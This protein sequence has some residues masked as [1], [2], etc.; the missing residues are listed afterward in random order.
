MLAVPDSRIK[1]ILI[2]NSLAKE[3]DLEDLA[4]MAKS[5]NISFYDAVLDKNI[6]SDEI[7]G[8]MIAQSLGFPF[9]IL[10]RT[11]IPE[12]LFLVT[13]EKVARKLKSIAFGKD[14]NGLK[15]AMND[16]TDK[17][18]IEM[19]SKKTGLNIIP[20]F[21]TEKDILNALRLL[22]KDLQTACENLINEEIDINNTAILDEAPVSKIVDLIV[23]YAYQDKASDIHIEPEEKNLLIRFRID[24]LLHDALR[25]PKNLHVRIVSRI[26]VLSKLRTDEHLSAQDGKMRLTTPYEVLDIRV[27]IIPVA[28]GEKVVLRL[29]SSKKKQFSL[30]NLGVDD[31][32]LKKI[33]KAL[34]KSYG[35]ILSTGPTGSGKTTIIYTLLKQIN[36]RE[37]NITTI[38]DPVEY[39]IA[40]ANQIQVNIKTN[41]TFANG[42]R[43]ILRQDPNVIF[44]GEIRDNETA[45]IAVN[46]ALTGHL[47]FSTLHT[48]D[49]SASIPRLIDMKVE[50]FLVASTVNLIIA[51]RL[52]RKICDMCRMPVTLTMNDLAQ[53]IPVEIILNTF[54]DQKSFIVFQGQGCKICHNTGYEGRIGIF[55]ILEISSE[56]R[57]LITT[58]CDADIINRQAVKEGMKTMLADG[59]NK[60][61]RGITT[62][63]EVLRVTKVETI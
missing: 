57:K 52:V 6:A 43:S 30:S 34:G 49:A 46:A 63:E 39:R 60:V 1:N 9:V 59:L 31:S 14:A 13:P 26:K 19:L 29:L 47:V 58:R 45:G 50:P 41:L 48:N 33:N 36:I 10:S 21:A 3:S 44:V 11:A 24:G 54:P 40:G 55:E 22:R 18:T 56:I 23:D 8:Q 27:S 42:L 51:Q 17:L 35:M 38:E 15:I 53:R 2:Q 16:P 7:I 61:A 5:S 37:R 20:Y 62:I 28:D 4:M 12:E 32:E 25:L